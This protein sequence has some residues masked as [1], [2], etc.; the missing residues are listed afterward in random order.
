MAQLVLDK[1]ITK[2]PLLITDFEN[3]VRFNRFTSAD[4]QISIGVILDL[5]TFLAR[6]LRNSS[7]FKSGNSG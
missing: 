1:R 3:F 5:R 7:E 4:Y 6:L 2:I